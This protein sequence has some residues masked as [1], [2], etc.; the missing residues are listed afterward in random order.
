MRGC[1]RQVFWKGAE[2]GWVCQFVFTDASKPVA[3]CAIIRTCN[4]NRTV[5][6]HLNVPK[7][8]KVEWVHEVPQVRSSAEPL[9]AN[10]PCQINCNRSLQASTAEE[11]KERTLTLDSILRWTSNLMRNIIADEYPC[12]MATACFSRDDV[13]QQCHPLAPAFVFL[14]W[15]DQHHTDISSALEVLG[16][17]LREDVADRVRCLRP[18]AQWPLAFGA[19]LPMPLTGSLE[20]LHPPRCWRTWCHERCCG[21]SKT[22]TSSG[23]K[24]TDPL[25]LHFTLGTQHPSRPPTQERCR[26]ASDG[27]FSRAP[28]IARRRKTGTRGT[29]HL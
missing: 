25:A 26:F 9:P 1:H 13:C 2:G 5:E 22:Q 7:L 21:R 14:A 18:G 20:Q 3:G 8:V 28:H 6:R 4:E 23:R 15:P 12:V 19:E 27:R 16:G 11:A 17:E 10:S 29:F 24:C